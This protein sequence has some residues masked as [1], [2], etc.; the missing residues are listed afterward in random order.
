MK[1]VLLE[2]LKNIE[3]I[4]KKLEKLDEEREKLIDRL[5]EN[6][7]KS[8]DAYMTILKLENLIDMLEGETENET[9]SFSYLN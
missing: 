7:L 6:E 5:I 2:I 1:E 8:I 4:K 9:C 3:E